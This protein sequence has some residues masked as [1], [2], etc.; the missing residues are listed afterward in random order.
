MDCSFL[1][2]SGSK[3]YGLGYF[4]NVT[5]GRVEKGLEISL[6]S[7]VDVEHRI[8]YGLSVQQTPSEGA[9]KRQGKTA[10]T[11]ELTRIDHYLTQLQALEAGLKWTQAI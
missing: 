3:T 6:I 8:G 11:T 9:P 5:A 2:K 7:I 4:Y 10:S 1:H